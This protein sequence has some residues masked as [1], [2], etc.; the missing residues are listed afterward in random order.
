ME[1]SREAVCENCGKT[2]T[3]TRSNVKFCC[4]DCQYA[5]QI[6]RQGERKKA[7]LGKKHEAALAEKDEKTA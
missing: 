1:R 6:K 2:F 3:T 4:S 7:L 5:A